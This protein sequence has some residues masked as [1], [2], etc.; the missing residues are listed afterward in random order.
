MQEYLSTSGP[1]DQLV[2]FEN[3]AIQ[4]LEDGIE[5]QLNDRIR[6]EPFLVPHRDEYTETVGYR[7]TGPNKSVVFIPDID[8]WER[9]QT[10]IEDVIAGCDRAYLDGSFFDSGEVQ[11]RDMSAFPHP[12]IV[13][14]MARFA[15]LPG[16]EKRKI[17]FIHFNH[18]NPV[19][20]Q[21]SEQANEVLLAGFRLAKE[22]EKEIL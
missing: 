6:I 1:W 22:G 4:P 5:I 10:E 14:S 18:T 11:G 8:K 7:I 15:R 2:R 3:I 17:S 20:Q 16:S 19:L 21:D 9:W 12:F 13:E